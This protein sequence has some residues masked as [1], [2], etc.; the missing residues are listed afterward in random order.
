MCN[1]YHRK[2][3]HKAKRM[4]LWSLKPSSV[5]KNGLF[6]FLRNVLAAALSLDPVSDHLSNV[7]QGQ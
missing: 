7:P 6:Y 4:Y 5:T 2:M 1:T 3:N